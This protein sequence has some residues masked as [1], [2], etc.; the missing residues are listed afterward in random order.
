VQAL[1]FQISG[2]T[3]SIYDFL[4][5]A[6]VE[7]GASANFSAAGGSFYFLSQHFNTLVELRKTFKKAFFLVEVPAGNAEFSFFS[8]VLCKL[9][10]FHLLQTPDRS[11]CSAVCVIALH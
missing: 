1:T 8:W 11:V 5:L 7:V 9:R 3:T 6:A 4:M 10:Y 2:L